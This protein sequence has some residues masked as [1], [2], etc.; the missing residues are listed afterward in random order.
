[1]MQVQS[2]RISATINRAEFLFRQKY[3]IGCY[4][5]FGFRIHSQLTTPMQK[6][7]PLEDTIRPCSKKSQR[8]LCLF[9]D[10]FSF[11]NIE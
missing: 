11:E 3:I 9:I 8:N 1:M 6:Y 4:E 5:H 7:L 2:N 10:E